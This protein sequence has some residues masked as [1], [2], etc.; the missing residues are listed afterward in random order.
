M[1]HDKLLAIDLMRQ[2]IIMDRAAADAL[3]KRRVK[4]L[5]ELRE[6]LKKTEEIST[7]NNP[8][9][10]NLKNHTVLSLINTVEE[11]Y[12]EGSKAVY[13]TNWGIKSSAFI[14]SMQ[15]RIVVQ[16]IRN[17]QLFKLKKK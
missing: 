13:H 10:P 15:A 9:F 7:D 14:I 2:R 1:G 12:N 3:D 17:K 6:E 16:A 5:N 8:S 4:Q 11:L